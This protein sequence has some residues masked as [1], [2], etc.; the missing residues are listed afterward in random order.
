MF[1]ATQKKPEQIQMTTGGKAAAREHA[2]VEYED[3]VWRMAEATGPDGNFLETLATQ[4]S[5][6]GQVLFAAD[7]SLKDFAVDVEM[8]R[9]RIALRPDIVEWLAADDERRRRAAQRQAVEAQRDK[10]ICQYD[11]RLADLDEKRCANRDRLAAVNH[12]R[13][14]YFVSAPAWLRRR[15]EELNGLQQAGDEYERTTLSRTMLELR[16]E[17]QEDELR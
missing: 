9:R 14:H 8:I 15:L 3:L 10:V 17:Q 4:P 12:A 13:N 6:H 11:G 5:G 7:K 2:E 1:P 16:P